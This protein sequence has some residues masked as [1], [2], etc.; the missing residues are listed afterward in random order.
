M[1]FYLIL[2]LTY[3]ILIIICT[4]SKADKKI[5]KFLNRRREEIINIKFG[6]LKIKVPRDMVH[7]LFNEA[8]K[9]YQ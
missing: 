5:H 2:L 7:R 4:D 6:A 9:A 1:L 3:K 8:L